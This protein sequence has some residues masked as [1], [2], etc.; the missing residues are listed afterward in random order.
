LQ[1]LVLGYVYST[2]ITVFPSFHE[3][4]SEYFAALSISSLAS[5]ERSVSVDENVS[6]MS[7]NAIYQQ[8]SNLEEVTSTFYRQKAIVLDSRHDS[9]AEIEYDSPQDFEFDIPAFVQHN[10]LTINV[11][12][13]PNFTVG[14]RVLLNDQKIINPGTDH[15]PLLFNI[16]RKGSQGYQGGKVSFK[17]VLI[18][19]EYC[20]T[21]GTSHGI[22]AGKYKLSISLATATRTTSSKVI[23]TIIGDVHAIQA[24]RVRF[25]KHNAVQPVPIHSSGVVTGSV[26]YNEKC[27]FRYIANDPWQMITIIAT[28][29]TPKDGH[30]AGDVDLYV[31]NRHNGLVAVTNENY[32]WRS[33]QLGVSRVDIMPD[34]INLPLEPKE[35][36]VFIIGVVGSSQALVEFEL[37]VSQSPCRAVTVFSLPP[38]TSR[39]GIKNIDGAAGAT[40]GSSSATIFAEPARPSCQNDTS[41]EMNTPQY[42]DV[43]RC[44]SAGAT[45]V[46]DV[47]EGVSRFYSLKVS[48][49][50]DNNDPDGYVDDNEYISDAFGW[51]T[52][53][54]QHE[55]PVPVQQVDPQV[56]LLV[57]IHPE[58]T[59]ELPG[60]S[61][62]KDISRH[63]CQP[64]VLGKLLRDQQVN[65]VSGCGVYTSD[66]FACASALYQ[67]VPP[68]DADHKWE[69]TG[70]PKQAA[71]SP[72]VYASSDVLYPTASSHS[73]RVRTLKLCHALLRPVLSTD[74][75]CLLFW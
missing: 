59:A 27:F 26:Q 8:L 36:R 72:V 24:V 39:R 5:D 61:T 67:E 19:G 75:F 12:C 46:V 57:L 33:V 11:N 60:S 30:F 50:I 74:F 45:T 69:G 29:L 41:T 65:L 63:Y 16:E 55:L 49:Q 10:V 2:V 44:T 21:L 4:N 70:D 51:E 3:M 7:Q 20:I 66:T 38:L 64:G 23:S 25:G 68:G 47:A 22:V 53:A 48:D 43:L 40:C 14:E 35:G 6:Y 56:C 15:C 9:F 73:W 18:N 1:E 13:L 71:V 42:H 32:I 58:N 34:D 62:H 54:D 28:P 17:A 31:T 52:A 37:S